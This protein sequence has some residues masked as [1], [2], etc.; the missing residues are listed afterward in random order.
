MHSINRIKKAQQHGNN[1]TPRL[2]A[3]TKGINHDIAVKTANYIMDIAVLYNAD[4]VVF[5]YLKF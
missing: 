3:K 2:W 4:I 1:K 5:V